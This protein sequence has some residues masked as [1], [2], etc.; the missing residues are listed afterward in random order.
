MSGYAPGQPYWAQ[1]GDEVIRRWNPRKDRVDW[2]LVY[3][4]TPSRFTYNAIPIKR[5]SDDFLGWFCDEAAGYAIGEI[6][7]HFARVGTG[8]VEMNTTYSVTGIIKLLTSGAEN[9]SVILENGSDVAAYNVWHVNND[10]FFNVRFRH[11]SLNN[12]FGLIGLYRDANNYICLRWNAPT[13]ANL[14]FVCRSGGVETTV[15]LDV[16]D[17]DWHE[18]W[19]SVD[20]ATVMFVYDAGAQQTI[21]TNIPED[22]LRM[23]SQVT[24]LETETK[25]IDM[26][27]W[28]CLEDISTIV[29]TS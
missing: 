8:T 17:G 24:T 26:D 12:F 25:D 13:S 20:A 27:R 28:L 23:Y 2:D 7:Y 22:A 29:E 9:D 11:V 14:F 4:S 3:G 16:I 18:F 10:P 19:M 1:I 15:V 5:V 6:P 21:T